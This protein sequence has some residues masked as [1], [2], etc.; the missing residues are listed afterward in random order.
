MNK[1]LQDKSVKGF[2]LADVANFHE[3][4]AAHV[5]KF[6]RTALGVMTGAQVKDTR[7]ESHLDKVVDQGTANVL[8]VKNE[9]DRLLYSE[10]EFDNRM[11]PADEKI[12]FADKIMTDDVLDLCKEINKEAKLPWRY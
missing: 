9:D 3:A 2:V 5:S 11:H 10:V 12:C 7:F 8:V 4:A 6:G 1:V